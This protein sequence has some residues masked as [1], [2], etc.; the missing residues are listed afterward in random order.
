MKD[1]SFPWT[2]LAEHL[3]KPPSPLS[4]FWITSVD[5]VNFLSFSSLLRILQHHQKTQEEGMFHNRCFICSL[6]LGSLC[7][8]SREERIE[9]NKTH[10]NRSF[11]SWIVPSSLDQVIS[12]GPS[13]KARHSSSAACPFLID[14]DFI[15][16]T[17][18]AGSDHWSSYHIKRCTKGKE[19]RHIAITTM[20]YT[21]FFLPS[22]FLQCPNDSFIHSF[23]TTIQVHHSLLLNFRSLHPP[24]CRLFIFFTFQIKTFGM[25]EGCQTSTYHEL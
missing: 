4:L 13:P 16:E 11:V 2:L 12:M 22:S 14:S 20:S 15:R 3:Y 21:L 10:R 6:S 7:I 18:R 5:D 19:E 17:N 9:E 24:F 25:K 23:R 8:I 1:I